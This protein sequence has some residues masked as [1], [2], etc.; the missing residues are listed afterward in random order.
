MAGLTPKQ[1]AF[2][3]AYIETGNASEAYRK[4]YAADR[5]KPESVN[6]KAKELLDNGKITARIA[7][8]QGEHRQRHNLTVDDLLI[9]LEEARRAALDSETAQASA[10]VGATMGK[11]KLL[12][13]DKVII[14]H[15]SGDGSMMPKPTVIQLLPV[16]PKNE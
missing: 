1:E 7:A 10:A 13:L 14:D 12:G 16:E 8:L 15:R 4:A 3:Q 6:R 11:A 9:E 5:M 2:C